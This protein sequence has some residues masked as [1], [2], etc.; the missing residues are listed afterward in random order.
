MAVTNRWA[1][2]DVATVS[3]FDLVTGNLKAKLDT[4]KM[5]GLENT[6]A[7][8]YAIGGSGNPK[9]VGFSGD[10]TAKF[11]LQDA[12]FTNEVLG[13]LLG[14]DVETPT[15][16]VVTYNE[17]VVV[18]ANKATL[19][20]LPSSKGAVVSVNKINEDG[21]IGQPLSFKSALPSDLEYTITEKE[22]T[23]GAGVVA[24]NGQIIVYYKTASSSDTK[25]IK[26]TVDKFAGSYRVVLDVLVRDAFTKK[27]F[28]AQIHVPNAKIEDSWKMEFKPDG[29]PG[30]LDIPMEALKDPKSKDLYTMTI[31]DEEDLA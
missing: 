22:I 16:P 5:S 9:L 4:L 24:D 12:L 8:V 28:A 3:F 14:N 29:D 20:F 1:V 11:T 31:Y 18:T 6:A 26:A 15:T 10:R 21:T 7:T 17:N 19:T 30:V 13:M 27:D 25:Q 2:R 23:L